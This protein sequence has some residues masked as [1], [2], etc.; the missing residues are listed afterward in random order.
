MIGYRLVRCEELLISAQAHR[1]RVEMVMR[2]EISIE[3][4][5]LRLDLRENDEELVVVT[6]VQRLQV[7]LHRNQ[8][9]LLAA[10]G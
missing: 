9:A 3:L 8:R 2:R 4:E 1:P 7:L 10:A 6:A 5:P